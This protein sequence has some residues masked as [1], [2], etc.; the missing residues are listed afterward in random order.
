M[1]LQYAVW[2]CWLPVAQIYFQGPK[3]SGLGITGTQ[4]GILS[5]L[6][7]LMSLLLSPLFGQLADRKFN[8]ERILFA[9]HLASAISLFFLWRQ[10]TYAGVLVFMGLHA[11][12]YSPTSP[13]S[14][15]LVMAHLEDTKK[16][17]SGIR[18]GGTIGWMVA[19]WL[20]VSLRGL[21]WLNTPNDFFLLASVISL[22]LAFWCLLLPKTPPSIEVREKSA[23]SKAFG[24]LKQRDFMMLMIISLCISMMFEFFYLF[25]AGYMSAP[26]E[27]TLKSVLPETY[28]AGGGYGLGLSP[29]KVALFMSVAQFSEIFLMLLLPWF[30]KNF[31]FKWTIFLGIAAWAT[32]FA[33]YV[34]FPTVPMTL[35]SIGLH[36]ACV[37]LFLIAGSLY[38]QEIAPKDIRA[39]AQALYLVVT[40]GMGRIIGALLAGRVQDFYTEPIGGSVQGELPGSVPIRIS[41]PGNSDLKEL[42]NWQ[43][44]FVIPTA[45]ALACLIVFPFVFKG[46]P[47][48]KTDAL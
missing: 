3:P 6:V 8:T 28:I 35:L 29:N 21:G 40:F 12:A 14:N 46:R 37:A 7:P 2:G 24:L 18:V 9:L 45:I 22:V 47:E 32:R 48:N 25:S 15:S 34:Y 16:S 26:T 5:A 20:L 30:L 38:V 23:I 1:F 19:G 39:S 27:Q 41:I 11:I 17:F 10:T 36:G 44:I 43:A 42:V 33:L 31:G 4:M 13:L